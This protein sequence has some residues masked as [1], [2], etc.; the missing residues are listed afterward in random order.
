MGVESRRI[1]T[2][3]VLRPSGRMD[4]QTAPDLE[5]EFLG[6]LGGDTPH[7]ALD[8][9]EVPYV[10]SAGLR[11][12]LSL[13]RACALLAPQPMVREVLTVSGFETLLPIHASI[14]ELPAQPCPLSLE[15]P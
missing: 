6:R 2:W 12:I 4:G 5:A 14:E 8:L 11:V 15:A 13:F 1:G 7:L 10:S 3:T 9:A